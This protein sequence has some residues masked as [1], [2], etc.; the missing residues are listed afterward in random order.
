MSSPKFFNMVATQFDTK[1]EV[2]RSDNAPELACTESFA[3]NGVLHLFNCVER[4][5]QNSVV[6]GKRQ[7]L[8]NVARSLYFQSRVPIKFRTDCV[9]TATFLIKKTHSQLLKHQTPYE[10]L[11]NKHADYSYLRVFGC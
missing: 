11:Y 6:E 7:H 2:F 4:P 5:Q 10:I 3:E 1:I 9:L 8:L